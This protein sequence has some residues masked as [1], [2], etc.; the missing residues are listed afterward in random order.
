MTFSKRQ[1]NVA[2]LLTLLLASAFSLVSQ[3]ALTTTNTYVDPAERSDRLIVKYKTGTT[4]AKS[5]ALQDQTISKLS[6]TAGVE[7]RYLRDMA[8]GAKVLRLPSERS[9]DDL[10]VIAA[11]IAADPTVEYAEADQRMFPA[12]VPS[13]PDY[14]RQWHLNDYLG[15]MNAPLAWDITTGNSTTVVAVLDSGLTAHP[16]LQAKLLPGYDFVS[17][18]ASANDGDGRDTDPADVGDWID[19]TDKATTRFANCTVEPSS[20]HGTMVSGVIAASAQNNLNGV[21]LDWQAQIL[22]VRVLGKCGG[23]TSDISDGMLWAAGFS[24]NGVPDNPNPAKI[25]NMSLGSKGTCRTTYQNTINQINGTGRIIVVSA[26][27]DNL[28]DDGSLSTCTGIVNVAATA[29]SGSKAGYSNFGT[30]ITIAAPGGESGAGIITTGNTG[31]TVIG[32]H[33]TVSTQGTSF[34][35]PNIAGVI[36]LMLAVRP[37]LDTV[38]A[39]R[40]LNATARPFPDATCSTSSCGAGIVDAAAA[41]RLARDQ[42]FGV[43]TFVGFSDTTINRPKA[44]LILRVTNY[45][46]NASPTANVAISAGGSDFSI[47][48]T[49]C[50]SVPLSLGAACNVLLRFNPTAFGNRTGAVAVSVGGNNFTVNLAGVGYAQAD[51]VQRSATNNGAP[52]YLTRTSDGNFWYTNSA[53]NTIGRMTA[54]GQIAEFALPTAS[55]NPFDIAVGGDG[56]VWFTQLDANRIGRITPAGVVTEFVVPT[57]ASQPRGITL[58]PDGNMWFTE[59]SGARIGRITPEGSITE[60]VIPWSGAA[61][62]G[63]AAGPDGNLWFTDSGIKAVGRLTP[64]GTFT[65]FTIPWASADARAI[66]AG[67]DGNMWFV[68]LSSNF[69]GRVNM[70]GAMT[71]F[72]TPR[73]GNGTLNIVRGPDDAMWYSASSAGRVGR[74][75]ANGQIT[76]YLLP[77]SGSSP[78]GLVA[79]PNNSL[80]VAAAGRNSIVALAL[81]GTT[82]LLAPNAKRGV[83]DLDATGKS[84]LMLR[85]GN[86][87]ILA[88]R[89]Q[90][91][92]FQFAPLADPGVNVRLVGIGDFNGDG[93]SDLAFQNL[94]QDPV[95]GEVRVWPTFAQGSEVLWRQVKKVWDVQVVGDLDGD[96]KADL[97]WRYVVSE[98][99]DTGVSYIWFSNGSGVS[100]VRKRGGAPLNW[101][102]LGAADL[103]SDNAADMIYISPEGNIRALMATPNRTC[104]NLSAGAL[105]TGFTALKLADFTGRGK[106][107]M[108][109]RNPNTGETRLLALNAVGL[110]LPP[111]TG[112]PDDQNAS[113]T[114]STLTVSQSSITLPNTNVGWQFFASGDFNGDGIVDIVWRLPNN[115][116]TVWLMNA[117][118]ASPNVISNAGTLPA[119]SVALPLQ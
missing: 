99:P 77:L 30:K 90:N 37:D 51:I 84:Q 119:N 78:T 26:G 105:P 62:R 93:K 92:V 70:N 117:N 81:N 97:V 46:V 75:D 96:G 41:V 47:T 56:N 74:I 34:S 44:D 50:T 14:A 40:I 60:F 42:T 59:I 6:S 116:F 94:V 68:E 80:W 86:T 69:I 114:A 71:S 18:I 76:E 85:S 13:D 115:T 11:K 65:S 67:A 1:Q 31:A 48:G 63:I 49:D 104:A 102:L 110:A 29:R 33:A 101:T 45:G 88:G 58:G 35:A 66:R 109:I 103:N 25:L 21:G 5:G 55:S 118:G 111:Y 64:S 73:T 17:D 43:P 82:P 106:G 95:F 12:L 113:C 22:P 107:D 38:S 79:G 52:L 98:S 24:V 27:N 4:A 72:T 57:A 36:S 53:S 91:N 61:P 20:W 108:L 8:T 23:F 112:A 89:F 28:F 100:Q 15:G 3:P 10:A 32:Q 2:K 39:T 54:D 7:L 87:Q 16:D 9:L 83:F 19:A